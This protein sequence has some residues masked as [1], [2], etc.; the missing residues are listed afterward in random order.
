M[1]Q[2]RYYI[3]WDE[4]LTGE[5]E[6]AK[7]SL[8]AFN[9][10]KP[11]LRREREQLIR[12]LFGKAGANCWI[13]SPFNCDYGY[14]ITVGDD[15]YANAG[16][17]ILDCAP[18]K[19]GNRVLLGPNVGIYPPEHAFD[20]T[21]RA[22]G[23]ERALPVVIEDD[24]W[25]GGGVTITGGVTIGPHTIIGA[26]SVVTKDIP[27]GVVAAGVPC[28]VIRRITGQDKIAYKEKL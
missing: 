5:R 25:I 14:H 11:S 3:S 7:D 1:L 19:I 28:R 24:V 13:E 10:L 16:C 23:Y 22:Q 6:R 9:G 27:G 21:E 12:G 20:R 2:G 15:F 26:G 4:E 18:V 17:C 8:F